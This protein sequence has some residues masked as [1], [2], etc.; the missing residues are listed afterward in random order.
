MTLSTT[1]RTALITARK[2]HRPR[3][4]QRDLAGAVVPYFRR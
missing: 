4:L 2:S 3:M 1:I